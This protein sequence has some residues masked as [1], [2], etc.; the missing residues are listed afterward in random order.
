MPE[1][2]FARTLM[3]RA[4]SILTIMSRVVGTMMVICRQ[5]DGAPSARWCW[6]VDTLIRW[7]VDMLAPRVL[8]AESSTNSCSVAADQILLHQGQLYWSTITRVN[9]T[10]QQYQTA[11]IRGRFIIEFGIEKWLCQQLILLWPSIIFDQWLHCKVTWSSASLSFSM[12]VRANL[13]KPVVIPYTTWT[14]SQLT[15][16]TCDFLVQIRRL[17][18]R[19]WSQIP[20]IAGLRSS[21]CFQPCSPSIVRC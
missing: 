16:T 21:S 11:L 2:P 5:E 20:K 18:N 7:Y 10:A 19:M 13:P 6:Y 9:Y 1:K 3:R 12:T 4:R 15:L 17:N 8:R 14:E